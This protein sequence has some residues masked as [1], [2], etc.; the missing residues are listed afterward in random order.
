MYVPAPPAP[1]AVGFGPVG[2]DVGSRSFEVV[3]L[4]RAGAGWRLAAAMSLARETP[5]ADLTQSELQRLSS[6]LYRQGFRGAFARCI[7]GCVQWRT[8]A[9]GREG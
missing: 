2:I 3:Q 8:G 5:G 6:V 9:A 4:R 1:Q 7:R